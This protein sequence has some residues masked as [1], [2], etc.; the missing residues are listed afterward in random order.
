MSYKDFIQECKNGMKIYGFKNG[1]L[2]CSSNFFKA[3]TYESIKFSK[4]F[5]KKRKLKKFL[6]EVIG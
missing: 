3:D 4:F 1:T 2:V 6:K 5:E